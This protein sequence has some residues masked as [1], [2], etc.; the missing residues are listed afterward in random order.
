MKKYYNDIQI[1]NRTSTTSES[2][3]TQEEAQLDNLIPGRIYEKGKHG[4]Y[5]YAK[6]SF[7]NGIESS[8][9][10]KLWDDDNSRPVGNNS[11]DNDELTKES[12]G[13]KSMDK[14]YNSGVILSNRL[15]LRCTLV[16]STSHSIVLCLDP[17]NDLITRISFRNFAIYHYATGN[18]INEK[19]NVNT[20]ATNNDSSYLNQYENTVKTHN[21]ANNVP[22]AP[23]Q[24]SIGALLDGERI[25]CI[26]D[27]G[28]DGE[29]ADSS[30]THLFMSYEINNTTIYETYEIQVTPG[31]LPSGGI[32]Q[33]ETP[34][35]K[36][37]DGVKVIL[38]I[39]KVI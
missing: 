4:I 2:V 34:G 10:L 24:I 21:D 20:E 39:K 18:I 38:T 28:I 16:K 5:E 30:I 22:N 25:S 23:L 7:F 32:I 8:Y 35:H 29:V 3:V 17:Y 6:L 27:P 19:D 31:D 12:R 26:L 36:D 15:I 11:A 1:F 13:K 9:L 33:Q 14:P 37:W